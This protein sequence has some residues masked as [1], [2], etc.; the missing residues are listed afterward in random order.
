MTSFSR[1]LF[2]FLAIPLLAAC[3]APGGTPPQPVAQVD[4]QRYQGLW[5][6]V[7]S[8][9]NRFQR[10]CAGDTTAGYR[11]RA[12]GLMEVTNRCR[13][14]AGDWDEAQ[15]IARVI[16]SD[17]NAR[18]EVSFVEL[19]GWRLFWGDYWI[20]HLAPDYSHVI[21][22]TPGRKYGWILA[23]SPSL[24]AATRQDLDRRLRAQGYDPGAFVDTGHA[25]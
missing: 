11:L 4:L 1:A 10:H 18:L 21:V 19:F 25:P 17:S 5:Y 14:R 2:S 13:T 23:R 7:A 15:G 22:G 12:D 9:P 20:L 16:D 24:P 8:I 6:E 3:Q